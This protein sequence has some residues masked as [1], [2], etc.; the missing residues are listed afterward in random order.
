MVL[1]SSQFNSIDVCG[2]R[3]P[4]FRLYG[5]G[6][7]FY[8]RSACIVAVFGWVTFFNKKAGFRGLFGFAKPFR[9]YS[10]E[11]RVAWVNSF[12]LYSGISGAVGFSKILPCVFGYVNIVCVYVGNALI[13]FGG[14]CSQCY[15][16]G[17]RCCKKKKAAGGT[18]I[19]TTCCYSDW[20]LF[21]IV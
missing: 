18:E 16:Q 4:S 21:D 3:C 1:R 17:V 7:W 19:C 11:S 5:Y 2:T 13:A 10:G 6:W 20:R 8:A 14:R 12:H 15:S 9:I